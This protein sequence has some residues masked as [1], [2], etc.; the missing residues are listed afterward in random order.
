METELTKL[1]ELKTSLETP[2]F[3]FANFVNSVSSLAI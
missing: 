1:T 2:K 3:N